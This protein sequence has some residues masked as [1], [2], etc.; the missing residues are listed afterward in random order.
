MVIV[1]EVGGLRV[2]CIEEGDMSKSGAFRDLTEGD[3]LN[4][5]R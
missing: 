2:K 4:V 3:E 5:L 1:L